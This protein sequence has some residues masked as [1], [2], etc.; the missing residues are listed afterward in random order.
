MNQALLKVFMCGLPALTMWSTVSAVALD[1]GMAES[2][3][4]QQ[5]E[6]TLKKPQP[7]PAQ[8]DEDLLRLSSV[9]PMV[10]LTKFAQADAVLPGRYLLDVFVN[11]Q[12]QKNTLVTFKQT[13]ASTVS[14]CVDDALLL[15]LNVAP[16]AI[17]EAEAAC[18]TLQER[19]PGASDQLNFSSLRL[20]LV[21]P[22]AWLNDTGYTM[23]P[24]ALWDKGDVAAYFDYNANSYGTWPDEGRRQ[25][26]HALG[27]RTGLHFGSWA[28]RHSGYYN[29]PSQRSGHYQSNDTYLQTE[30]S[31]WRSQLKIGDFYGYSQF[32]DGVKLRGIE[33]KTDDR[34]LPAQWRGYA[35][36][37]R[38]VAMTHAKVTIRQQQRIIY[39]STVPPGAFAIR[40]LSP[41]GYAGDLNVTVTEADGREVS[42]IVPFSSVAQLIRPG[43]VYYSMALGR[44]HYA[45]S[46]TNDSVWQGSMQYGLTNYVT[47]NSAFQLHPD[48][49][50]LLVG[51]AFNT[52]LGAFGI[53]FLQTTA[54]MGN[55]QNERG[56]QLKLNYHKYVAPTATTLNVTAYRY[57]EKGFRNLDA[58]LGASN[59]HTERQE[60]AGRP[61]QELAF[62]VSQ[63]LPERW[64]TFYMSG[65]FRQSWAQSGYDKE[66]QFGYS[67]SYK[68]LG[69]GVSFNQVADV[70]S[71]DK[72]NRLL[73]TLSMP[74]DVASRPQYIHVNH[75]HS[76]Q[77]QGYTQ[78]GVS[79][80]LD[81]H[82][83]W[84][85]QVSANKQKT[86]HSLSAGTY[87]RSGKG[88]LS[89]SVT[90]T[91]YS[92]QVSL[93]AS[94]AV[95][96]HPYGL[97]LSE[98]LGD[99]FAIVYAQGAKGAELRNMPGTFLNHQGIAVLSSVNPY[100]VN[101]IGINPA[102]MPL[103]VSLKQSHKQLVPRGNTVSLVRFQTKI[104]R[105]VL[106][107]LNDVEG[108]RLPMGA[109]V[110]NAEGESLGFV[111]QG[112]R[113]L[114][115]L[116]Q[117][118]GIFW[119]KWGV[120]ET[121]KCQFQ[122]QLNAQAPSQG[123]E[124]HVLN[125]QK[126]EYKEHDE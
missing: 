64:G 124:K 108:K 19:L 31:N 125:C 116:S 42:F 112:G 40:D 46:V 8:F 86:D 10:D 76:E 92:H 90:T 11:N 52:Q 58:Y 126:V 34:M 28:L 25:V 119:V 80:A 101:E 104:G 20:N 47:V 89:A 51:S 77:E 45:D 12:W 95:V 57:S 24:P 9:Y 37:V 67:N 98:S 83:R 59:H 36:V 54:K 97:T 29:R 70:N 118:Q 39:E 16:R 93:G 17:S 69:Y 100:E 62:S 32:I 1:E 13:S 5:V 21:V 35:P 50:V 23:I 44:L 14:L 109:D 6:P 22:Q 123:P 38:G 85:Y 87:Y 122:Y 120:D 73:L 53:D 48:F 27:I 2:L 65:L 63:E 79:G 88:N 91:K 103:G 18:P 75:N 43:S 113:T 81:Q 71:G 78:I 49:Q 105:M 33:L 114:L 68:R 96:L 41:L 74:F 94:G 60:Y 72:K 15:A 107:E 55:G 111:G 117:T 99:A 30:L 7:A 102:N 82:N 110:V 84:S 115:Q 26:D 3:N 56:Q 106:F 4:T 61:K 121:Q 66:V